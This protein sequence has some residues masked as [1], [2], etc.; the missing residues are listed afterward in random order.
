MSE[1]ER[2]GDR[3]RFEVEQLEMDEKRESVTGNGISTSRPESQ[4]TRKM[5]INT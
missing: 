4:R 1:E 2:K 5:L 3:L